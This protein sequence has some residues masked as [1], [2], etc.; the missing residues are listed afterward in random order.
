MPWNL[1][2]VLP[3]IQWFKYLASGRKWDPA[4]NEQ[5]NI[6]YGVHCI[7]LF[8]NFILTPIFRHLID[9]T[10]QLL[11]MWTTAL[12]SA[13]FNVFDLMNIFTY[14]HTWCFLSTMWALTVTKYPGYCCCKPVGAA[15]FFALWMFVAICFDAV[16]LYYHIT[17]IQFGAF[18]IVTTILTICDILILIPITSWSIGAAIQT[19]KVGDT[20]TIKVAPA[21]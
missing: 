14:A 7:F 10:P 6:A 17:L 3:Y 19:K 16:G 21:P 1:S 11:T 2:M 9:G 5:I 8:L 13:G 15:R 18:Y 4:I 12:D 20:Q